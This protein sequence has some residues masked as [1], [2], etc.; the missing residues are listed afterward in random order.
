MVITR[1]YLPH[2]VDL[3]GPARAWVIFV[4]AGIAGFGLEVVAEGVE[5]ARQAEILTRHGC[6]LAQGYLFS[7]PRELSE[8][9]RLRSGGAPR[10]DPR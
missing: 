3:Y 9:R 8:L 10:R 4:V 6:R 2:V 1:Q 5:T 7:P